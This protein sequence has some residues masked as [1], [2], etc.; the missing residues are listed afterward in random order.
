MP[1]GREP[2][3]LR[4]H[5]E[6]FCAAII[7]YPVDG[8]PVQGRKQCT[9]AFTAKYRQAYFATM[10]FTHYLD[11]APYDLLKGHDFL[12]L[13]LGANFRKGSDPRAPREYPRSPWQE[14]N[15][16]SPRHAQKRP[17]APPLAN[18]V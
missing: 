8:Q 14:K 16:Q 7:R 3:V 10:S 18:R 9:G 17:T 2:R 4:V 6:D 11:N 15:R 1:C 12:T 13:A 5:A